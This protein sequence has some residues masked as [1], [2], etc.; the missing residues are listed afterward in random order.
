MTVLTS[1]W[2]D[3]A[4]ES[5]FRRGDCNADGNVDI[6]DAVC[7]LEWLFSGRAEPGCVAA[8]NSNG[9]AGADISDAT[10]LLS[11]LFLGGPAPV[12][13]F[14]GCGPGSLAV[15]IEVGCEI[16]PKSCQQ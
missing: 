4:P 6:S 15:D 13:P 11:F 7:V 14:S 5:R 9:D 1:P 16:P 10:Y 2:D 8:T 12:E 3:E